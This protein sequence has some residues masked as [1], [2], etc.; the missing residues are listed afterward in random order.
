M[1]ENKTKPTGKSVEEF[2]KGVQSDRRRADAR[3]VLQIM[4][5]VTGL[6][7]E[8]WGPSLVGF[9]RYHYKYDSGR[10]GDFFRSGFSPRKS[11]LVIY[12]VAGFEPHKELMDR[13][14]KHKT[15]RSC[16]YINKLE[17]VDLAVLEALIA[18]SVALMAERYP[19]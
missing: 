4:K 18:A 14:G 10:E 11:S 3:A 15:G 5:R 16:L 13:L 7:P 1:A 17:D 6:E 9:G 2:L 8:L 19:A 12:L